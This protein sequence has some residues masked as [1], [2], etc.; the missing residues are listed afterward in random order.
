MIK[1]LI[2]I[3]VI[4]FKLLPGQQKC[5]AVNAQ[6]GIELDYGY[7]EEIYFGYGSGHEWVSVESFA[8]YGGFS[9]YS[10]QE[11]QEWANYLND[12]AQTAINEMN[13]WAAQF[14]SSGWDENW[15]AQEW[16]EY[17]ESLED[18][19]NYYNNPNS[20]PDTRYFIKTDGGNAKY[21]TGDTIYVPQ[22][23]GK[24][25]QLTF[26]R[27]SSS[28][29]TTGLQWKQND[30]IK[31][32]SVLVCNFDV[33]QIGSRNV[34]VD[35]AGSNIRMQNVLIVY[36]MP[37]FYF[38]I[39]TNYKGEYGFDDSSHLHPFIKNN[40]L[41]S[42]GTE[43][44]K[45]NE[46]T[47]YIVPWVSSLDSQIVNIKDSL[48]NLSSEAKKDKNGKI[49]LSTS[50]VNIKVFGGMGGTVG[51][52]KS[53]NEL[54]M[55][56]NI[57]MGAIQWDARNDDSLKSIGYIYAITNT[58]DTIGKLNI[59][60][61]KPKPKKVLFVYVNT[62][63]GYDSS[64]LTKVNM[65]DQLNNQSHNQLMR[66]WVLDNSYSDTLDISA[67]YAAHRNWFIKDSIPYIFENLYDQHKSFSIFGVNALYQNDEPQ[68]VHFVFITNFMMLDTTIVGGI[69]VINQIFGVAEI[70][71]YLGSFYQGA[72]QKEVSHEFGHNLH[73]YH[74]FPEYFGTT[75]HPRY[76]IPQFSTKNF[77]DYKAPSVAEKRTMFYYC[78][79]VDG[80]Y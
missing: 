42:A 40:P 62:G 77:M 17:L 70:G 2:I 3:L 80:L 8:F 32:S 67:E 48:S 22:R 26:A 16:Y 27:E 13:E 52:S 29:V 5:D 15:N 69:T 35:S 14:L 10:Q 74:I 72:T 71:G 19:V 60:C 1:R 33:S 23:P 4:V 43:T 28:P 25:V 6:F 75:Y 24:V 68:K 53:Y 11:L 18:Y 78:Q 65:L 51:F 64:V 56:N 58:N 61:A 57:M 34:K 41:Y 54:S 49:N 76:L 9:N 36:K 21:F 55:Q 45:F 7:W 38:K 30:T 47:S 39:G 20:P 37:T 66:K 12:Y 46:D 63:T 73:M 79:W 50:S 31:C 44:R 59:S